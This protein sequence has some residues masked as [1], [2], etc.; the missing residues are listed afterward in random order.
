MPDIGLILTLTLNVGN[1]WGTRSVLIGYQHVYFKFLLK[2]SLS[3]V[4]AVMND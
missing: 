4:L 3:Y 2:L 1:T